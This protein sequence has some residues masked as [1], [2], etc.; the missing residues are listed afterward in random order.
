[1]D[2]EK[3][4]YQIGTPPMYSKYMPQ[5]H[6]RCDDCDAEYVRTGRAK[7]RMLD[8]RNFGVPA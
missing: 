4:D 1:M 7:L 8:G 5:T 2:H 3:S 6:Y